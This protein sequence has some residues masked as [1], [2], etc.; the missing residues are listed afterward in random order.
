MLTET[1]QTK[2]HIAA[3]KLRRIAAGCQVRRGSGVITLT[4]SAGLSTILPTDHAVE[5][6]VQRADAALYCAKKNGRNRTECG[7][8]SRGV[9]PFRG[10]SPTHSDARMV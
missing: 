6:C 2:A 3:E 8:M 10:S 1:G 7:G 4:I 5:D 9:R